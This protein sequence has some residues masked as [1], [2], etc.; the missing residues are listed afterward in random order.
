MKTIERRLAE[1]T[2]LIKTT[3]R[4]LEGRVE[5]MALDDIEQRFTIKVW[6]ALLSFDAK[7]AGALPEKRYVFMCVT[8]EK[9]DLLRRVRRDDKSLEGIMGPALKPGITGNHPSGNQPFE[10]KYLAVDPERVF[11]AAEVEPLALPSTLTPVERLLVGLLYVGFKQTELAEELGVQRGV[12][13]AMERS[14]RE[15]LEDWRPSPRPA[16]PLAGRQAPVEAPAD[17]AR[18]A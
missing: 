5:G 2:G 13:Q 18:A 7:K 12:I 17:M 4:M 6:R 15:K 14:I 11:G 10:A 16:H 3:A 9:V 8:S 1:Y